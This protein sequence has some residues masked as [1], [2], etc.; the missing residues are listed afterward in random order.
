MCIYVLV[1]IYDKYGYYIYILY[2]SLI[3]L[4]GD[5]G[6]PSVTRS[7]SVESGDHGNNHP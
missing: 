3:I 5:A 6:C 1:Y 7:V 2:L 4:A